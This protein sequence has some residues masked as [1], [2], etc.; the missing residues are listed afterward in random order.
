MAYETQGLA[1]PGLERE[2]RRAWVRVGT[3]PGETRFRLDGRR[4]GLAA[5]L[6][7]GYADCRSDDP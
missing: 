2:G 5:N 6:V 7:L 3:D 4:Y 1:L